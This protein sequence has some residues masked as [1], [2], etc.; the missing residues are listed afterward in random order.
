MG[1]AK[2]LIV[3][4]VVVVIVVIIVAFTMKKKPKV[5]IP[6]R[7]ADINNDGSVDASD[8][9]NDDGQIDKRDVKLAALRAR[10]LR[11][12]GN[13]NG[14]CAVRRCMESRPTTK[15]TKYNRA[16]RPLTSNGQDYT[17]GYSTLS[18]H[19]YSADRMRYSKEPFLDMY[20]MDT[21]I[22]NENPI[23]TSSSEEGSPFVGF[24]HDDNVEEDLTPLAY[25]GG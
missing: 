24:L 14:G 20:T 7:M 5:M 8:D 12:V 3:L 25:R 19:G 18:S 10:A 1:L 23:T 16:G 9:L 13:G 22:D 6:M 4:L 21:S 11:S 17:S 15:Y 2:V